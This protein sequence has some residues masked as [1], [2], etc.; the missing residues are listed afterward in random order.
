[1]GACALHA[2]LDP[3]AGFDALFDYDFGHKYGHGNCQIY[4]YLFESILPRIFE[5]LHLEDK[6]IEKLENYS[7]SIYSF[8]FR[9]VMSK[10]PTIQCKVM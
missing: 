7:K 1:M 9:Q 6:S 2:L 3:I 4:V 5:S 10:C 8:E